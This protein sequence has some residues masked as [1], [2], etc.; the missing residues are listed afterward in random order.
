[1]G[2]PYKILEDRFKNLSINESNI[3]LEIGSDMGEG[4]TLFFSNWSKQNNTP[5]YSIDVSSRA[6]IM[7]PNEGI[8]FEIV[9]SGSEWCKNILP[10]LNKKIKVLY[11]DN[12][13]WIW[14]L[15]KQPDYVGKLIESYL[16]RGV[17]MNNKNSQE[18][19]RLQSLYLLPYMDDE[20]VV[21]FDDTWNCKATNTC[22]KGS[23]NEYEGKGGTSISMFINDGFTIEDY[24]DYIVGFRKCY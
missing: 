23:E 5:F 4:S 2:K 12:F 9:D 1:M 16:Q 15:D 24:K 11:L 7:Y 18:E 22:E 21:I 10:G 13:D 17:I 19:H 20:S 14:N 3:V 6:K 8:N